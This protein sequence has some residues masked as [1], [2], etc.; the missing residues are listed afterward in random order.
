MRATCPAHLILLDLNPNNIRW[1]YML[2]SSSLCNFLHDPSSYL[3]G[4]NIL[5]NTLFSKTLSLCSSFKVR[6][7]VSHPHSTT[8]KITVLYILI[9]SFFLIW[10]GKTRDF[11]LNSSEYSPN[12]IYS[13]FHH[14]C[15]SYFLVSSPSIWILPHFQMIHYLFLY[16]GSILSSDDETWSHILSSLH[17]FLDKLFYYPLTGS[18]CS[19]LWY[20]YYRPTN[21]HHHRPTV[22]V[23]H[24]IAFANNYEVVKNWEHFLRTNWCKSWPKHL[25]C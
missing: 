23:F 25:S 9:F 19:L 8:D 7:Q 16:S 4:P 10:D 20:L 3:L 11:G 17:L 21:Y 5:L 22:D 15:H 6:D 24:S 1:I 12:L 18:P 13:W 2:W 14:E